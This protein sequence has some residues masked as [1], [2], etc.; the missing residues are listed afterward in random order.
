[1]PKDEVKNCLVRYIGK[2][3]GLELNLPWLSEPV[4]F[5]KARDQVMYPSEAQRL[6]EENPKGFKILGYRPTPKTVET[7]EVDEEMQ[8]QLDVIDRMTKPDLIK[9]AYDRF[10]EVI[11]RRRATANIRREMKQMVK[12]NASVDT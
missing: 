9:E 5:G 10:G 4:D 2:K 1:M 7:P 8:I 6:V 3:G 11:D 12:K